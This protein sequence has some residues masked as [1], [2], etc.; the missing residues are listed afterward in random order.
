MRAVR[1]V[2]AVLGGLV[3]GGAV[4]LG[5][6]LLATLTP[7]VLEGGIPASSHPWVAQIG[8][9]FTLRLDGLAGCLR[10]PAGGSSRQMILVGDEGGLRS[11]LLTPRE[12]AGAPPCRAFPL[13]LS[14]V[15]A[16]PRRPA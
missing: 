9:H 16:E 14:A 4:A 15:P 3:A 10:T 2:A 13:P 12:G 6:G 11:R 8:L 7:Q 5:L 1:F